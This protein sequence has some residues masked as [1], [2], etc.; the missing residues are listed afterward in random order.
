MSCASICWRCKP[1]EHFTIPSFSAGGGSRFQR[2]RCR[3]VVT[4]TALG[5]SVAVGDTLWL[6]GA[7][8][9]VRVR[10]LHAQNQ[11]AEQAV[12][13][14]RIALNI[15]GDVSKDQLTRGDWL[16]AQQP[17]A[18]AERI[19]VA[20]EAMRRSSTG[21]R[22]IFT[23]PPAISPGALRCWRTTWRS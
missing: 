23:M 14:Q 2:Q 7:D 5:G 10:G 8:V 4:G 21:S 17:P 20:I 6:T 1:G 9:P 13:G 22:Y 19:L 3:L 15:S 11:V 16:L 12:A 18:A